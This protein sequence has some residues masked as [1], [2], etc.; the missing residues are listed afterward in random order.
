MGS[1]NDNEKRPY[2]GTKVPELK[3][4]CEQTPTC[5]P[6]NV[7]AHTDSIKGIINFCNRWDKLLDSHNVVCEDGKPLSLFL[8]S[9]YDAKGKRATQSTQRREQP[10]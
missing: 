6:G 1:S 3:V 4:T 9:I 10:G 8:S 5:D 7:V 2:P